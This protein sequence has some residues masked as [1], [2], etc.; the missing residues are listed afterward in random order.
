LLDELVTPELPITDYR[1]RFSGL[2][3]QSFAG[4]AAALSQQEARSAVMRLLGEDGSCVLI[5]HSLENDLKALG[6]SHSRCVDTALLFAH[7]L[8]GGRKRKVLATY[9]YYMGEGG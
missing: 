2:S 3:A 8:G 1:T 7:P 5:G 6:L 4:G 9:S